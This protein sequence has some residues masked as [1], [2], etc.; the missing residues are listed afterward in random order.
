MA[1]PTRIALLVLAGVGLL[2]DHESAAAQAAKPTVAIMYFNNNVFTKDARDYDGLTKGVP[3]FLISEMSSNP[4]IR[5]IERDQVQR[6]IDEQKLSSGGQVDRETAV[7]VGKLLGAQ[8]MIFGGFMA[9]PKGN[10]RIDCRAVNVETGAIEYT[11]R[12]QDHGDNVM[13]LIGQLASHLNSGLKLGASIRTGDAGAPGTRL[14]M[15]V[16]VLYGKALD[17]AD[18][19]DKA[20]AVELFGAV[21]REFPDYAPAKT[22]LAKVKPGG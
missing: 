13:A 5:V 18:R 3:D 8:H 19:G 12:V 16:A 15:R 17:M 9:D 22:G 20:K 14:P 4:N 7:K 10:F 6:L 1:S 11:D 21:L 2:V